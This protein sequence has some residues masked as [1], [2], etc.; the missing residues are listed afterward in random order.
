[1][2]HDIAAHIFRRQEGITR[3]VSRKFVNNFSLELLY[4]LVSSSSSFRDK[5]LARYLAISFAAR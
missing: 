2:R 3:Y 5:E 1:M 4:V